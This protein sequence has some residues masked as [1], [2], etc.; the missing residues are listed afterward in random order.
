MDVAPQTV[1]T[2]FDAALELADATER[3]AMLDRA[4]AGNPQLRARVEKL[5]AAHARSEGFF[6]DCIPALAVSN[7]A[8][9][10]EFSAV[11]PESMEDAVGSR[12][13]PYKLLQKI[14]EGGCGVVYMAE[15]ERP[16]RRRVALKIIKL[17]MDTRSVIARFE[18]ERQALALMD[19]PNIARVLDAGATETGRPYFVMELVHGVR[20]TEYCD[21][22]SLST[23]QR[24]ELF[25]QV[26]HAI[27]HA[28]QKGI[29]H[30]DIK[31]SNVL[32]TLH[33]GV[34]VPKV[35]DF[36]IA[37]AMEEKLT[38]KTLFTMF[39]HFIGTPAYMSPEQAQMSGLDV[40]TRSDIYSLGVL[41]YELLTGKTPFDQN[42]LMA[43]GLDEMRRTLRER[44]PHRPST[45][46]DTLP[47]TELTMTAQ[48]RHVEP[49]GLRF[50]LQGDLDWVVMKALEKDRTRRYETAYGLAMD[51][52][53]F[54]HDEPVVARPPSRFYR[55]R[56]LVQRNRA[57][58]TAIGAVAAALILGLSLSTFLFL[59][60]REA[61]QRAVAAEQE[62]ARLRRTA[63]T[64]EKI[65]TAT[66]FLRGDQFAEADELMKGLQLEQ[67][68]VEGAAVLRKLGAW[69][70][71]KG[72]WQPASERLGAVLQVNQLNDK[73]VI[74]SDFLAAGAALATAGETGQFESFRRHLTH[75]FAGETSPYVLERVIKAALLWPMEDR[76][77]QALYPLTRELVPTLPTSIG[78]V[79]LPAAEADGA[80]FLKQLTLL[81]VG[82]SQ[83]Y[84]M[85]SAEGVITLV[86]GGANIWEKRDEFIYAHTLLAGDFDF[87]MQVCS[88]MPKPDP[89]SRI[90]LMAR[91]V[92]SQSSSRHVM[93]AVNAMNSFQVVMRSQ[94]GAAATSVPQDPLPAAY[95][96]NSWVRLQRVGAIFHAYTSSNGVDWLQLYQTTGGDKPFS[97][98]IYFGI[99]ASSHSTNSVATNV[100]SNLGATPTV[101]VDTA[102]TLAL[103]EY[104]RGDATKSA[105]W[106]RRLLAYPECDVMHGAAA[107]TLLV[108]AC[109]KLDQPEEARQHLAQAR[110]LIERRL[111]GGLEAGNYADGFWFDWVFAREL[112][113]EAD[114]TLR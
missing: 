68:T 41:L 90:G 75:R 34:P 38:D 100:V 50:E 73:D 64:R 54:L 105:E 80:M 86:A 95:A 110:D 13:G 37:K 12:I 16:V 87:R 92:P 52:V 18:A 56:K 53:R 15:Q 89:Y 85:A 94:V 107:H 21:K 63:E 79:R 44:E 71:L 40:D 103:L 112:L 70:A 2:L 45:K 35:I 101:S 3:T 9:T 93:V 43:S 36:G 7:G 30:R 47:N 4:C 20:I 42:E 76:E 88:I 108:L 10:A 49:P 14:G 48:R 111:A 59:R 32:V 26:C 8:G 55:F 74:S 5:L 104:R 91:E 62:Q 99:A 96:S 29:I 22:S 113:R 67:A 39:G 81:D 27:Q 65:A 17:G 78:N 33:D 19:H 97:D 114:K 11:R 57:L 23:R 106:C 102:L 24:L 84:S 28:H 1:E 61:R 51:I 31:P 98:P 6:A 58:F 72:R 83:P 60:E 109:A 25:I 77:I 82:T 46:L 69:H 66:A